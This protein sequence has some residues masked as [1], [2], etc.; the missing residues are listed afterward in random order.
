MIERTA[1]I[2]AYKLVKQELLKRIAAMPDGARLGTEFELSD[3]YG[4]SRGTLRQAIAE[5]ASEGR[6]YKIQGSGTYKGR[7]KE[8]HAFT[9]EKTF[10]EQIMKSG[11]E[12]GIEGVELKLVPAE[13]NIAEKLGVKEGTLVY[14]LFRIRLVDKRR[15]A[16][17]RA[18]IRAE[19]VPGIRAEDLKM[20]LLAMFRER[21]RFT[22]SDGSITCRAAA[23]PREI[24]KLLD[25]PTKSPVLCLEHIENGGGFSPLFV[26]ISY[27]SNDYSLKLKPV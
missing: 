12:P 23:A 3:E 5:L 9:L 20:S 14:S 10:T 11:R 2:P 22:L 15:T 19:A 24:A 21:F 25:V 1:G 27:F 4:V 16:C 26:D 7:G 6:I 8:Q 17:C 13:R 18:Y